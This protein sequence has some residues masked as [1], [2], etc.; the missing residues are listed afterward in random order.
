[1][2]TLISV[3]SIVARKSKGKAPILPL[4]EN[5]EGDNL[6]SAMIDKMMNC[7][8]SGW[9]YLTLVELWGLYR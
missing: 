8:G 5:C 7:T 1:M 2:R 6:R 9:N 4:F 3:L